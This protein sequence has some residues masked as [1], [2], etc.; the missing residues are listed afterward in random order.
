MKIPVVVKLFILTIRE[1]TS[2]LVI[3][4]SLHRTRS[5][6]IHTCYV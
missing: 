6:R 4:Y 3:G 2:D 5:E 1:G